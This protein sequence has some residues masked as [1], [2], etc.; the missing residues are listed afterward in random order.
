MLASGH[1]NSDS[2]HADQL[3][4]S[5]VDAA[6]AVEVYSG[7]IGAANLVRSRVEIYPNP[8]TRRP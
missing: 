5:L 7:S 3:P 4:T 1:S 6:K 8:P 2:H